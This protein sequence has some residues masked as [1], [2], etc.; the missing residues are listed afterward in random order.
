MSEKQELIQ[1]MIEMQKMFIEYEH[2]HGVSPE[3][4]F[5]KT[6]GELDGYREKYLE[7][8]EKLIDM[9]HEEVGSKRFV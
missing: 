2:K 4:Y 7:L 6:G 1:Q 3:E 5:T 9:A 8:T